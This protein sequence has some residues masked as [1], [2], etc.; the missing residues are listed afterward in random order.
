MKKVSML[1][2]KLEYEY[3]K[4][5]I[6]SSIEKCLEHQRW[7]LGPEVE[8]LERAIAK[9][10]GV[11]HCIG[12][13]SGTDAL[14]ISLRAMAIKLKEQEYF[15]TTDEII[16]TPFTFTATGDAILRS[17]ARPVFVDIEPETFNIDT[18]KIRQYLANCGHDKVVGI[19]PVHLYGQSCDMDQIMKI[20]KEYN[21][22]VVEDVAQAFGGKWRQK[23]IGTIGDAGAF[24]F[25]P[26]KNLGGF[27]DGGMIA[28][29][30]DKIADIARML[31]RHGGM[32]KYNVTHIG[33]NSRL[34]TIQAA[35]L[36]AKLKYVDELN[37]K[38]RA[39]AQ[40]YTERLSEIPGL[41]CPAVLPDA[42]HVY[43]Q[44]TVRITDNKRDSVRKSL[45]EKG[46]GTAVYYPL[47]LHKMKVF[48]NRVILADKLEQAEK[49]SRE[50]IS[51]PI[52]PLLG[53]KEQSLVCESLKEC[54]K[55][56]QR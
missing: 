50:V 3:M 56:V 31:L 8:Q 26:S 12:V 10:L 17:G 35:T 46:I 52:E 2:L 41:A 53:E 25:F 9:Y 37:N 38:R 1:D 30:D 19:V 43:N 33:Y 36:L 23:K 4:E 28:T 6:D 29:E 49:A 32:D 42:H 16:T 5:D 55:D 14:A 44:Y 54:I 51:L 27:G 7:I 47:P 48:E 20:A 15:D 34:D 11:S 21:L 18:S 39:I 22:F 45:G 24:S 13:A 40:S